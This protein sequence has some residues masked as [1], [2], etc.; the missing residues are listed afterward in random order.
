MVSWGHDEYAYNIVRVQIFEN[1]R[2]GGTMA[3]LSFSF[4]LALFFETVQEPVYT[5]PRSPRYASIPLLLPLV[6]SLIS[7]LN[8]DASRC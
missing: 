6:S 5:S 3:D 7:F 8:L 1:R 4:V 2:A